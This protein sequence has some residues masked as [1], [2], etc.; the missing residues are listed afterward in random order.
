M[1]DK[2]ANLKDALAKITAAVLIAQHEVHELEL[3]EETPATPQ[4]P[5]TPPAPPRDHP[6]TGPRRDW[7]R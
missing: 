5:P 6:D 7:A 1:T 4:T 3:A 2:Y